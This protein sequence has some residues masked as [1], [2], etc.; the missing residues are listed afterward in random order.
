MSQEQTGDTND[1]SKTTVT[2]E[3]NPRD[4]DMITTMILAILI[5]FLV[6]E[7]PPSIAILLEVFLKQSYYRECRAPAHYLILMMYYISG[8]F[9][10]FVYFKLNERYRAQLKSFW[11]LI[12]KP[13]EQN[14]VTEK[15]T[16]TS[17]H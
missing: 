16:R 3:K 4:F 12:V 8:C 1:S 15:E 13:N 2:H 17:S 11:S 7:L 5:L 14:F 9:N 6:T 10:F